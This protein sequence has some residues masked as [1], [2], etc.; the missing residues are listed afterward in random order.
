MS[1]VLLSSALPSEGSARI[2]H[3][4]SNLPI[5]GNYPPQALSRLI[6]VVKEVKKPKGQALFETGEETHH[7][8]YVISGKVNLKPPT[9]N[10]EDNLS[11]GF[12]GEEAALN[13]DYY[14]ANATVSHDATLLSF[15]KH[16]L[17][18]IFSQY[19]DDLRDD[20]YRSHINHFCVEQTPFKTEP[21]LP[22]ALHFAEKNSPT[23]IIGW[24]LSLLVPAILYFSLLHTGLSWP[25]LNFLTIFS[26]AVVMWVFALLPEY[27]PAL[28]I[29]A[30]GLVLGLVPGD[31]ILS[32]Y[33]SGA[34]FMALS[35]FGIGSV[36]VQSGLIYRIALLLLRI[37]PPSSFWYNLVLYFFGFLLTPILPMV[38]GRVG[39]LAPL[40]R[41]VLVALGYKPGGMAATRLALTAFASITLFSA[42]FL[43]AKPVNFAV[44]GFF[45]EQ[46]RTQ[47]TWGVWAST[48]VVMLFV[49]FM[50]DFVIAN[51]FFRNKE[52]PKLRIEHVQ[53]QLDILGPV[54]AKEWVAAISI[55]LLIVGMLTSY[56][57]KIDPPWIGLGILFVL[58]ALGAISKKGFQ[59]NID[60]AFLFM[61]GSFVGLA[62][63]IFFLEIDQW[64]TQ[65]LSWLGAFML[66][67]FYLFVVVL[68]LCV[69]LVRIILP[70]NTT[71]VLL[72]SVLVPLAMENGINPWLVA[73][74]VLVFVDGW[75]LSYQ[76]MLYQ[77]FQQNFAQ[78][79]LYD[80]RR[81]MQFNWLT[82]VLSLVAVLASVPYWQYIGLL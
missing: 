41:D 32:G 25:A 79:Q 61:L 51:F 80:T 55:L 30:A 34:F 28:L 71:A 7:L 16:T 13:A 21:Q 53:A 38:S 14:L 66:N 73:F 48:A 11:Q 37:T 72:C 39:I 58:L 4:L 47:F 36:L 8:Y 19:G 82:N 20:L 78:Q 40:L 44:F 64:L 63:T 43:T 68:A 33:S 45:P 42:C 1:D 26:S 62:K 18:E 74:C 12:I 17:Q 35:I 24:L 75:F 31:V 10:W 50:L 70:P 23:Q 5:I 46:I 81:F 9:Q 57:H 69:H 67:N 2:A 76:N 27:I 52:K 65:Y 49:L 59:K 15:P 77:Q 22:Q 6:S 60:W 29:M 56:M 3:Y 54:S